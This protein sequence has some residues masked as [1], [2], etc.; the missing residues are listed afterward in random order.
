MSTGSATAQ[1]VSRRPLTA[2]ARFW[3]QASLFEVCVR[4]SERGTLTFQNCS[5][6]IFSTCYFYQK[7]KL[8][9]KYF[10]FWRKYISLLS[11]KLLAESVS[12]WQ[13]LQ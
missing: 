5:I 10:Q 13:L 1:A 2:E 11:D 12:I 4:H 6:F 9:R 3:L 8:A 7:D